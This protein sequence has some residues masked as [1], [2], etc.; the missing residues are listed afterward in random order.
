MEMVFNIN[1]KIGNIIFCEFRFLKSACQP[2]DDEQGRVRYH[3]GYADRV[4]VVITRDNP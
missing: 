4:S 2:A 3:P 1:R